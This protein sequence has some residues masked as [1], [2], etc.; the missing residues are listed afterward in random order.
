MQIPYFLRTFTPVAKKEEKK[1]TR[2]ELKVTP[3][4]KARAEE[5]AKSENRSLSNFIEEA[6]EDRLAPKEDDNWENS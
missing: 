5:G 2:I 6:V 1:S 3:S 4:F